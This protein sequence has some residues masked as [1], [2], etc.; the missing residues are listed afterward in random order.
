MFSRETARRRSMINI[1]LLTAD[2]LLL[3]TENAV[4]NERLAT[5][6]VVKLFEEIY[7][8]KLY[9][10]RGYSSLFEMAVK[11]FGFCAGS[12]QRRINSMKLMRELPEIEEKI[13]SGELSL[14]A[15]STLQGFFLSEKRENKSY[16]KFEKLSLVKS[17]LNKSTRE[18]ER[19]LI[20]LSPERDKKESATYINENR[21]RISLSISEELHQKINHLKSIW[22]HSNPSLSTEVLLERVVEMALEEVDPARSNE[23]AR[24]RKRA[25]I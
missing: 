11:H 20:A 12:A 14:T 5:A 21:L 9:L 6:Q 2:Q 22:S 17:C 1:K 18:V 7:V 15:A 13:E 23:R 10:Q 19:E 24:Q 16:S 4:K 25:H 8:R 3:E